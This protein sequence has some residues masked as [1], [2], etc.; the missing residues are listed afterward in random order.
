ME[1]IVKCYH[2]LKS[3]F[4]VFLAMH[5]DKITHFS[6][7]NLFLSAEQIWWISNCV[8]TGVSDQL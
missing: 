2:L 6:L 7:A 3:P 4:M 5:C 8:C 1:P